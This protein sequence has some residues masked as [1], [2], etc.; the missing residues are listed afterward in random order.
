[1]YFCCP[2]S[3]K[4]VRWSEVFGL[5]FER[6]LCHVS[7]VDQLDAHG[8]QDAIPKVRGIDGY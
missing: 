8:Q 1:M 2:T 6:E 3:L 5:V 7:G 4:V